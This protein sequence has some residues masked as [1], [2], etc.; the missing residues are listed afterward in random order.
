M[1]IGIPR[2]I[3]PGAADEERRGRL[4]GGAAHWVARMGVVHTRSSQAGLLPRIVRAK[5]VH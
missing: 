1:L 5:S 2:E 4:R 3:V